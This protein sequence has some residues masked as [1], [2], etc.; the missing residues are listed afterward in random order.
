[1]K[2]FQKMLELH[3]WARV[4]LM[5]SSPWAR[6][7]LP[8]APMSSSR[9]H[10]SLPWAHTSSS[11]AH[12]S[13]SWALLSSNELTRAYHELMGAHGKLTRARREL[14]VSSCKTKMCPRLTSRLII[15]PVNSKKKLVLNR[16]TSP[17]CDTR[18]P[19]WAHVGPHG[20]IFNGSCHWKF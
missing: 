17:W 2:N 8:W 10:P 13:S 9:A 11:R 19:T 18:G 3:T 1:M 15:N 4:E 6:M 20:D 16:V 5:M 14:T 7:S 12:T